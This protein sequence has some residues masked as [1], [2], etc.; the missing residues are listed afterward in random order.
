MRSNGIKVFSISIITIASIFMTSQWMPVQA[1]SDR[2]LIYGS[3]EY[4]VDELQNRLKYLGYYTG[5]IDGIF[6]W[7]TYWA[8]RD[9]QY[10]FGM[11]V[12]GVVD[13]ATKIMLIKATP[14]WHYVGPLPNNIGAT[15][16]PNNATFLSPSLDPIHGFTPSDLNL[17]AHVVYAEARGEPFTAQVAVASVII[18]RLNSPKFPKS[19]PAIIYQPGAFQSV[20]NG[21]IDLQPNSEAICAVMDAVHGWDPVGGAL[22]YVNPATSSSP[23]IWSKPEI[24]Q[25]GNQIFSS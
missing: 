19:I 12:T 18:N 1:F 13:M 20:A 3:V 7:E 17:M 4:S 11:K 2:N 21:Q 15:N 9:F 25:I 14:G 16:A 8:V 23:W 24:T 22:Y 5:L 6:G 10:N